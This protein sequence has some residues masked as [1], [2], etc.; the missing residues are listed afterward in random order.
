M[1]SVLTTTIIIITTTT[2]IITTT[3]LPYFKAVQLVLE[4]VRVSLTKHFSYTLLP[5]I[6]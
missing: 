6:S 3:H 5:K 1:V 2:T 4:S